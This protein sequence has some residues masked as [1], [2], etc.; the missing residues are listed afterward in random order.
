MVPKIPLV[1]L[2]SVVCNESSG[3]GD[4]AFSHHTRSRGGQGLS[5][6]LLRLPT[7][8]SRS[9]RSVAGVRY[10][11]AAKRL[12]RQRC[13]SCQLTTKT[14]DRYQFHPRL[15]PQCRG[16][17]SMGATGVFVPPEIGQGVQCIRGI[18]S[19]KD[20]KSVGKLGVDIF[21]RP[22]HTWQIGF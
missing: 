10:K 18:F 5:S 12:L 8:R 15:L 3:Q 14:K 21:T 2:P 11:L 19:T 1:R 20:W 6:Q 9:C 7:H 4:D 17:I 16:L 13:A 22:V